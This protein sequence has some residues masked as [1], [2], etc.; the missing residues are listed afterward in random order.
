MPG[1]SLLDVTDM[2][3]TFRSAADVG[4]MYV[5]YLGC[6]FHLVLNVNV[7]EVKRG[8]CT[9]C[10]RLTLSKMCRF[11]LFSPVSAVFLSEVKCVSHRLREI[12]ALQLT[13]SRGLLGN[14]AYG[15]HCKQRALQHWAEQRTKP[16]AMAFCNTEYFDHIGN[17]QKSI[18]ER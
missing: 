15:N 4:H 18:H 2:R 6:I 3:P 12:R 16:P 5:C 8:S 9:L 13:R 17:I 1:R 14:G 10:I 7:S 11:Y